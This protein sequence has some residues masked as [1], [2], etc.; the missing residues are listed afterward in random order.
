[1]SSNKISNLIKS[2]I[3]RFSLDPGSQHPQGERSEANRAVPK[4]GYYRLLGQPR[5]IIFISNWWAAI[6]FHPHFNES[7]WT[8][9]NN[10]FSCGS[11]IRMDFTRKHIDWPLRITFLMRFVMNSVS[12]SAPSSK[13]IPSAFTCDLPTALHLHLISVTKVL[14]SQSQ[15]EWEAL[16]IWADRPCSLLTAHSPRESSASVFRGHMQGCLCVCVSEMPLCAPVA[17]SVGKNLANKPNVYVS[18]SAGARWKEVRTK[19][20]TWQEKHRDF[21][22][23]HRIHY[24]A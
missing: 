20:D 7:S 6:K 21:S 8:W 15:D 13:Y 12:E 17:G 14:R 16:L 22:M 10:S 5:P 11:L 1:M 4:R 24:S 2:S 9:W 3:W 23:S 18:S 19:S